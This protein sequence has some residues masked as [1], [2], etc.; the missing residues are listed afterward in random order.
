MSDDPTDTVQWERRVRREWCT[1][2]A[3]ER[4]P[5]RPVLTDLLDGV[6]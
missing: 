5:E 6:A 1:I 3:P 4:E 2:A